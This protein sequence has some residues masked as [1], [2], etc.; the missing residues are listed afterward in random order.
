MS[1]F[2]ERLTR[3]KEVFEIRNLIPNAN[4]DHSDFIDNELRSLRHKIQLIEQRG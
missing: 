1:D 4:L 3:F 2:T